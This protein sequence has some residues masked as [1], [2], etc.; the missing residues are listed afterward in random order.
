[1]SKVVSKLRETVIFVILKQDKR[2]LQASYEFN[3]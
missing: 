2:Q 3:S 1:M